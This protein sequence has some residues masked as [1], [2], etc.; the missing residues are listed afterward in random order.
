MVSSFSVVRGIYLSHSL[1]QNFK[2]HSEASVWT[3]EAV[4]AAY[5]P[6]S[7]DHSRP[8]SQEAESDIGGLEG[9]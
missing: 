6:V 9:S 1:G 3:L 7:L 4:P 5:C 2:V 8:H